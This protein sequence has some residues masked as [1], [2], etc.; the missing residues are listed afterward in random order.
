[1]AN[2]AGAVPAYAYHGTPYGGSRLAPTASARI[3]APSAP[4]IGRGNK[5][6][7]NDDTCNAAR[8][9]GTEFCVG[10]LRSKSDSSE[11]TN[12]TGASK[13]G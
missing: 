7:A 1:M 9:K 8:S 2:P 11:I 5:C 6:S 4:F 3:A 13:Q 10:H 12:G